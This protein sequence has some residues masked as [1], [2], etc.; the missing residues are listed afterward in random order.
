MQAFSV[1]WKRPQGLNE[2]G[3]QTHSS[4]LRPIAISSATPS[5]NSAKDC[6]ASKSNLAASL[7]PRESEPSSKPL[8][9]PELKFLH[10]Q[11][12]RRISDINRA[13]RFECGD[14]E[15]RQYH[16]PARAPFVGR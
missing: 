12:R 9:V 3:S 10:A 13:R 16:F 7:S 11:S 15:F 5:A 6:S 4:I 14:G 8:A 2:T 1:W